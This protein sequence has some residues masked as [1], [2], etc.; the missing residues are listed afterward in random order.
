V[1]YAIKPRGVKLIDGPRFIGKYSF[2]PTGEQVVNLNVPRLDI[3]HIEKVSVMGGSNFIFQKN[4]AILP[5]VYLPER[6]VCPAELNGIAKVDIPSKTVSIFSLNRRVSIPKG[7]SLLG[8][9]TGNYAHWLTETLPKLLLVDSVDCWRD[10]PLL[11]DAWIHPNF[12]KSIELFSKY[13]REIFR[14]KRWHKVQVDSLIDVSPPSYVPPEYRHFL[15][16]GELPYPDASDF[17][18][19]PYA[20]S[21][22]RNAGHEAIGGVD[23]SAPKKLY[24][25]RSAESCGNTRH[26]TNIADIERIISKSGYTMLDPA[27]L[28]FEEQI[29]VFSNAQ[30]II[31]PLGAALANTIFTPPGCQVLGLAPW[32]P[33]AS[34]Y[35]FSN[36]MGALDHSMFYVLGRQTENSGHLLHKNFEVD[37]PSFQTAIESFESKRLNKANSKKR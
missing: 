22:L 25:Y 19:S 15:E 20:L 16:M 12:V 30:K 36:F 17:P 7:I 35:Y 33:N 32:Y 8:S 29:R 1:S 3:C 24:L 9:C 4:C 11:V 18:F 37:L 31:S 2:S 23:R 28:S 5:D 26:V 34:Y 14:I 10:Y 6:D 13:P 21:L 27:K